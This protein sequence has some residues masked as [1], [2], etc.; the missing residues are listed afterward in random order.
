MN[1]KCSKCLE[2]KNTEAF[3]VDKSK[4]RGYQYICKECHNE[5]TRNVWYIKN[6]D[7]QRYNAKRWKDQNKSRVLATRY[8]TTV[9][10]IENLMLSM[11][12][13]CPICERA[14]TRPHL[15]HNHVTGEVRNFIC[16][17]CNTTLGLVDESPDVLQRM[18]SYIEYYAL[19]VQWKE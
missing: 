12:S 11:S 15:D 6:R 16:N 17:R 18:I 7:K 3:S 8:N 5:Y 1:L 9:N 14:M 10:H 13:D 19:V 4:K 2:H